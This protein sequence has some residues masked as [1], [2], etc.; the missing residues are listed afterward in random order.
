MKKVLMIALVAVAV[1]SACKKST[2]TTT[3]VTDTA[4][5]IDVALSA[6]S[7]YKYTISAPSNVVS[8]SSDAQN[9]SLSKISIVPG[10]DSLTQ[11]EYVPTSTFTGTDAVTL[12][13]APDSLSAD[14]GSCHHGHH[15]HH[16]PKGHH[17]EG[18]GGNCGNGGGEH[19]GHHGP[20]PADST[21]T[22]K[23]NAA[24]VG[25]KQITIRFTVNSATE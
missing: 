15:G 6:G 10:A 13:I 7:S 19:H 16:G 11:Y 14:T 22:C 20:P 25:A 2:S 24:A 17:P 5:T 3:D 9:A 21:H 12:V 18:H 1:A 4:Q 23:A 8:I